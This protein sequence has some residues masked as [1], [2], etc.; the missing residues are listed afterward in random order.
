M[1]MATGCVHGAVDQRRAT[2]AVFA[3]IF[4]HL[5]RVG[6]IRVHPAVAC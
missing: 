4:N 5:A 3:S 1:A 6:E 2:V